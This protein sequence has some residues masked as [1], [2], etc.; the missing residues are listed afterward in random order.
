MATPTKQQKRAKRAASKAKQNRM[1]RSG[2]A[3]KPSAGDSASVEQVYNKAME[4]GSYDAMFEKM[5]EAQE[6]GLVPMISVFLVDPLLALVLKGHKEEHATDYI[7]LVF[8][9]YRKWLDGAD[10]EATMAW[11]E[12]DEFQDAY[13]AA[14][15]LV[16]KQQQQQKQF[17]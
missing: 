16:A 2:Q 7:V 10:E 15:E 11:L 8:N 17:G 6:G 14:S 9:A 4:S 5:K 3:V 1:V 12:S 13:I